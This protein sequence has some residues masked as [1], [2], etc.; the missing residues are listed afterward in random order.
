MIATINTPAT[1]A[2]G[3]AADC[4]NA[5]PI[6]STSTASGKRRRNASGSVIS[7]ATTV[8][9]VGDPAPPL[10][11]SSPRDRSEHNRDRCV[12]DQRID[13]GKTPDQPHLERTVT[14]PTADRI[15]RA[16]DPRPAKDQ[17]GVE[18]KSESRPIRPRSS[19]T[20]GLPP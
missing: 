8:R 3:S 4:A 9:S 16:T 10:R 17:R 11:T 15:G 12:D 14:P 6:T 13:P 19:P 20:Y 2:S 5:A 18:A 7:N 1:S